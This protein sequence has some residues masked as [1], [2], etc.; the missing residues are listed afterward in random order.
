MPIATY[1][2]VYSKNQKYIKTKIGILCDNQMKYADALWD[3]GATKTHVTQSLIDAFNFKQKDMVTTHTHQ[4]D[5]D[6]NTYIVTLE[7]PT[8][9]IVEDLEV[10]SGDY[11]SVDIGIIIGMDIINCCDLHMNYLGEYPELILKHEC[12]EERY[13]ET[14][15]F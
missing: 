12:P 8:G 15:L 3:T 6:A 5:I 14:K 13:I 11:D 10:L 7:L 4:G 9:V 1:K 2:N